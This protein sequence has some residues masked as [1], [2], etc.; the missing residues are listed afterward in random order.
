MF[1]SQI[2]IKAQ[3]SQYSHLELRQALRGQG[4]GQVQELA[5]RQV[6]VEPALAVV[7]GG[8]PVAPGVGGLQPSYRRP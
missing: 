3:A 4:Q 2:F 7:G 6:E 1:T 5:G 8:E